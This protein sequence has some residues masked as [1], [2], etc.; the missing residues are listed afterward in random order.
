MYAHFFEM[1]LFVR[2]QGAAFHK[3]FAASLL[4]L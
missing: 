2:L 1:S 4:E 3:S